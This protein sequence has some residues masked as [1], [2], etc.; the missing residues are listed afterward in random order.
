V[1]TDRN[2]LFGVLALQLDLIDRAGFVNACAAWATRKDTPLAEMLIALGLLTPDDRD[3]VMRLLDRK[4]KKHGGDVQASL[5]EAADS[6]VRD[7][8]AAVGV[9]DLAHSL[10]SPSC[11]TI[12]STLPNGARYTT[13]RLAGTGGIGRV[14]LVRDTTLARE[15]AL[16]ELRPDRDEVGFWGRFV[17]E[18]QV[19]GQ[20]EHPGI[21]PVY[22]LGR[23]PDD[24][25]PFY[26]M[27]FVRG[28]TLK[29]AIA[30]YHQRRQQN[31]AGRRELREL[32]GAFVQVC[33]AVGYAHSRGVLHRD[34]KPS[35]VA[36]GDYGEVMVL[37]WGL[38]KV[39][40]NEEAAD[41]ASTL[42][43]PVAVAVEPPP[44]VPGKALGTPAYMAPEQA[45]G[46]LDL[47]DARTDVYGLGAILYH[48]LTGTAPFGGKDTS[49]VLDKVRNDPPRRPREVI[50]DTPRAL[51]AVC[52]KALAKQRADRYPSARALTAEVQRW[53]ADEPLEAYRGI[54]TDLER[55]AGQHPD[56][57]DYAE[58]LARN[59]VNLGLM[60]GGMGR[61]V[62]AEGAFRQS[63]AE[64]ESLAA[65]HPADLRYRAELAA[66][67]FQLSRALL[68]L[69]RGDEARA[70]QQ[71]ALGDYERL[72]MA[73]PRAH[74]YHSHLASVLLTLA[75]GTLQLPPPQPAEPV[76]GAEVPET[77]GSRADVLSAEP[78][79][80][81]STVDERPETAA[82]H[83][84]APAEQ[85]METHGRLTL[86][87]QF[88]AGGMSRIWVARDHDLNREVAIK[89]V[90]GEL[91]PEGHRRFL[92]EAQIT[93]QLEHPHI[94]PVYGVGHRSQD[95]APFLMMR[96]VR[97]PTLQQAIRDYH[98]PSEAGKA[99]GGMRRLLSA[100]VAACRA[101]AY[102][103][104]R[105][106]IHRDPKSANIL[107]SEEG[108]V[109]VADWGLAR[110][111]GEPEGARPVVQVSEWAD[112]G[113]TQE[114]AIM[115][116]PAYMSPEQAQGRGDQIDARND[117][118]VLGVVLFE[119]LTG[120]LPRRGGISEMLQQL[121]T[122]TQSPRARSFKPTVPAALDAV[123]ARAMAH[124]PADR[125]P[126]ADDLGNDVERWLAG[127][128]VSVYPESWLSRLG[129]RMG[130]GPRE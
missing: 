86:L 83:A 44:T 67:R 28:R 32:L 80:G 40:G 92:R 58:Q 108:E 21:V 15:V 25:Q 76:T 63:I 82:P 60:L 121:V 117:V 112:I 3:E 20:L 43:P 6:R 104:R 71:A 5:A 98:S 22:E 7:A 24:K 94:V 70:A 45:D 10:P 4:V 27:R 48:L 91:G 39:M 75:P 120:Q 89:E 69:N 118:Y 16:K 114:G 36:Q 56:V 55:L 105:G 46:R 90:L 59:R 129:R 123:C 53:L 127:E 110:L 72:A 93:A 126:C 64:Y 101:L 66:A 1:D 49:E 68:A 122:E 96:L 37:D 30:A 109:M 34:L 107:L 130:R 62:E 35:N 87:E 26:T 100:F 78:L 88:A 74:E 116:T 29:D 17:H 102:A 51:E 125:Y 12:A 38:A 52:L 95:N 79:T 111:V 9:A 31:E 11:C 19:T 65:T 119:I 84:P 113:A 47:M 61:H 99:V 85:P 18:A 97:G 124:R 73:N 81:L 8:V 50:G 103:H 13:L 2:L 42:P 41:D 128:A 115:G 14:W 33:Q 106:V 23:R 54:V 57:P 77:T